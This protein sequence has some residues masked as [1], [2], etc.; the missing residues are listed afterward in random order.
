MS[1]PI[2][3]E[4]RLRETIRLAH[5]A[6]QALKEERKEV[7]RLLVSWKGEL[8]KVMQ[9]YV[10]AELVDMGEQITRQTEK[11]QRRII[12]KFDHLYDTLMGQD[13]HSQRQGK[14]SIPELLQASATIKK[15]KNNG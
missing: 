8:E 5:E 9:D 15:F 11:G 14:P 10:R 7:E 12:A 3:D 1:D 4:K 6:L 13:G 2:E